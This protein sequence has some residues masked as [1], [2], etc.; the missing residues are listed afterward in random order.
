MQDLLDRGCP[1]THVPREAA[2][3]RR[4]AGH[5]SVCRARPWTSWLDKACQKYTYRLSVRIQVT[6]AVGTRSPARRA[7]RQAHGQAAAAGSAVQCDADPAVRP[8]TAPESAERRPAPGHGHPGRAVK[9]WVRPLCFRR[10]RPE[11]YSRYYTSAIRQGSTEWPL[12]VVVNAISARGGAYLRTRFMFCAL[13]G[14]RPEKPRHGA[15]DVSVGRCRPVTDI[16]AAAAAGSQANCSAQGRD[17][18]C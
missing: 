3:R 9:A 14:F 17:D 5:G 6:T 15:A 2:S 10:V 11:S 13:A 18:D 16:C 4:P 8:L 12:C 7:C 1:R